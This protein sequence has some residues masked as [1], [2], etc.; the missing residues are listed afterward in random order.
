MP[1]TSIGV[2]TAQLKVAIQN[3]EAS[4]ASAYK[5][6][7]F[8]TIASRDYITSVENNTIDLNGPINNTKIATNIAITNSDLFVVSNPAARNNLEGGNSLEGGNRLDNLKFTQLGDFTLTDRLTLRNSAG[9]ELCAL[10]YN[11]DGTLPSNK[12]LS[13]L[14]VVDLTK[15]ATC[16]PKQTTEIS[17]NAN[18]R[19]NAPNIE[20]AGVHLTV[21]RTNHNARINSDD[22]IIIPE[23]SATSS[24]KLND[25][26]TLKSSDDT[27]TVVYGGIAMAIKPTV[28][29]PIF[30]AQHNSAGFTFPIG[31]A[32]PA[33]GQVADGHQLKIIVNNVT[34][35]FTATSRGAVAKNGTFNSMNTLANAINHIA[36]LKCR[37][38]SNGILNIAA[39]NA[40]HEIRFENANGGT[41]KETL[42]LSNVPA[43]QNAERFN[44][45]NGLL[46]AVNK[47]SLTHKLK[48]YIKNGGIQLSALKA[49]EEFNIKIQ[50]IATRRIE[51]LT[52]GDGTL[53]GRE[54][55]YITAPHH[56]LQA[57]DFVRIA[58]VGLPLVIN[59]NYAVLDVDDNGFYVS[60][61]RA[62]GVHAVAV[63]P[64]QNNLNGT[65][66][67][68]AARKLE[69]FDHCAIHAAGLANN[70]VINLGAARPGGWAIGDAVTVKG[71]GQ[72]IAAGGGLVQVPDGT[73]RI[74][75]VG[76]NPGGFNAANTITIALGAAAGAPVPAAVYPDA[77]NAI[78]VTKIGVGNPGAAVLNNDVMVTVGG[79][80]NKVRLF[81]N[82]HNYN[83]G[84]YI[85][86]ASGLPNVGLNVDNIVVNNNISYKVVNVSP[87]RD[88]LDFEVF[89]PN[90]APAIANNG[91]GIVGMQG[92]ANVG[93]LVIDDGDRTA[94]YFGIEQNKEKYEATYNA[95]NNNKNMLSGNIRPEI[96]HDIIVYDSNGD[97]GKPIKIFAAPLQNG[98]NG[99]WAVEMWTIG[100]ENEEPEMLASGVILFDKYG[101]PNNTTNLG[102]V[103]NPLKYSV[104]GVRL[105]DITV[106][107]SNTMQTAI[108]SYM[109][110]DQNGHAPGIFKGFEYNEQTADLEMI[111]TNGIRKAPYQL[112][113]ASF[114]VPNELKLGA[115]GT[116]EQTF[117]SGSPELRRAEAQG[118]CVE[119]S[120]V[121][122][123]ES[124][125]AVNT[126]ARQMLFALRNVATEAQMSKTVLNELR[127]GG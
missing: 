104:A 123:T 76:A 115:K 36:D 54:R 59:D 69:N 125:I 121:N 80:S 16:S 39:T 44:T 43:S 90:G 79:A 12:S 83:I 11:P 63:N 70:L 82:H 32:A 5:R 75:A 117:K 61:Q 29:K 110:Y 96:S 99:E 94:E 34:Y 100:N 53:I 37:F 1:V 107:W 109:N 42:G 112:L 87:N 21:P 19:S 84:D 77:N 55:I 64:P 92:I 88:Y 26:I 17:I 3:S 116:F 38:D 51:Q 23:K 113:A 93:D 98:P 33:A 9:Y 81:L 120:N 95:E 46:K 73:Y 14:T 47:D 60:V 124:M 65:W 58:G 114:K 111:Y 4:Q 30:G 45:I 91:N 56:E 57:G 72:R 71:I 105:D 15:Y 13:A 127:S 24:L 102:G 74:T 126:A 31:G 106:N 85:K 22:D 78:Q 2:I 10:E 48:A 89:L 66:E 101:N 86:F 52:I 108:E 68:I 122:E 27:K 25:V 35:K 103:D 20:A 49:T 118:Y 6:T 62:P 18:F 40:N 8:S 28:Q 119:G 7:N 41:F 97:N 67:K 50:S